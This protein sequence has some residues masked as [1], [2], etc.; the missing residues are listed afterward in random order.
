M[1]RPAEVGIRIMR[2]QDRYLTDAAKFFGMGVFLL[3]VIVLVPDA[4]GAEHKS[5]F[6]V[7]QDSPW[8]RMFDWAAAWCSAKIILLSLS[9]FLVLDALL[10]VMI[11][12]EHQAACVA[13]FILAIFPVLLGFFGIYELVKAVL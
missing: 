2:K 11:R 1:I 6:A 4:G 9:V 5:F 12:G 3:L 8:S 13:L 7:A 10:S